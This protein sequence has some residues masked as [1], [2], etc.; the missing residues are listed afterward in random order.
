MEPAMLN[1]QGETISKIYSLQA[2]RKSVLAGSISSSKATHSC[3]L[4][5]EQPA[6]HLSRAE[7]RR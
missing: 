5:R 6:P 4:L 2:G 3:V 7:N 1:M